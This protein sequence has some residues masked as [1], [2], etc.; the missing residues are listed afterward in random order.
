MKKKQVF[1]GWSGNRSRTIA[2]ALQRWL[3][4]VL[5][6]IKFWFSEEDLAKGKPWAGEL[7]EAARDSAHGVFVITS[8]N[9]TAQWPVFEAGAVFKGSR[10]AICCPLLC[11]VNQG[12][13]SGPLAEFQSTAIQDRE[14]VYRLVKELDEACADGKTDE[15]GVKQRFGESWPEFEQEVKTALESKPPDPEP[16]AR[17]AD[18]KPKEDLSSFFALDRSAMGATK[19]ARQP[20]SRHPLFDYDPMTETYT[21]RQQVPGPGYYE[22]DPASQTCT[23]RTPPPLGASYD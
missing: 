14:D 20:R 13:I 17:R 10:N 11:G 2:K 7:L 23:A 4:N 21:A 15:Q 6:N 5:P 16:A 18:R 22:Y 1:I 9:K 19:P 8:D 12:D 3:Q